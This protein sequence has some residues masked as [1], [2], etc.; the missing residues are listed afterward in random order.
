MMKA[1]RVSPPAA[2]VVSE[3]AARPEPPAGVLVRSG[4]YTQHAVRLGR[5]ATA[6]IDS[7]AERPDLLG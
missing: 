5:G 2:W 6:T 1:L 7:I 4:K 3:N